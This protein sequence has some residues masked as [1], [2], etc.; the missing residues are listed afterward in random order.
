MTVLLRIPE[1]DLNQWNYIRV[2]LLLPLP[3]DEI[4]ISTARVIRKLAANVRSGVVNRALPCFLI[5]EH[6]SLSKQPVRPAPENP[7]FPIEFREPRPRYFRCD[8]EMRSQTSD[9]LRR[10]LD[11]LVNRAAV[12]DALIAVIF[13]RCVAGERGSR[14]FLQILSFRRGT[15]I[16]ACHFS[17]QLRTGRNACPCNVNAALT[18]CIQ[19]TADP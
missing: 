10:H 1:G 5:Q 4:E 12:G 13:N 6:A 16:L 7:L 11:S 15:G 18:S 19:P 9:V 2:I 14:H 17:K 3:L 8:I